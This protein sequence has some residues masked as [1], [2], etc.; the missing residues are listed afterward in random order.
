[1]WISASLTLSSVAT[2]SY[3]VFLRLS[4]LVYKMEILKATPIL[5]VITMVTFVNMPK[6]VS[7]T[8][9]VLSLSVVFLML[10]S[11]SSCNTAIF[12]GQKNLVKEIVTCYI[13]LGVF[14]LLI[15]SEVHLF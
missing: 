7:D 11:S 9:R 3:S 4:F 15:T 2:A 12:Y 8:V 13:V 14:C 6:A 5:V 10:P 1:M